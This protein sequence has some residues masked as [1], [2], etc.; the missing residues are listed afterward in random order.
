MKIKIGHF[1]T[2]ALQRGDSKSVTTMGELGVLVIET[3]K[4]LVA[5]KD[6]IL[7]ALSRTVAHNGGIRTIT[8]FNQLLSALDQIAPAWPYTIEGKRLPAAPDDPPINIPG[9][10]N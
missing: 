5:E 9:A 8:T 6:A 1:T 4:D 7:D 10:V 3:P 2:I